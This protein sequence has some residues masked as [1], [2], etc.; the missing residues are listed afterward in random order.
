MVRI[1]IL[2][3]GE[4]DTGDSLVVV[5]QQQQQQQRCCR[6]MYYIR[7]LSDDDVVPIL[8]GYNI[9]CIHIQMYKWEWKRKD[10]IL[11]WKDSLLLLLLLLLLPSPSSSSSKLLLLLL[12]CC[13]SISRNLLKL[14]WKNSIILYCLDFLSIFVFYI[15]YIAS[16][17]LIW[18]WMFWRCVLTVFVAFL[19]IFFYKYDGV[20]N[21]LYIYIR[22]KE[23]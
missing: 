4:E 9:L 12:C 21:N 3:K 8:P 23:T 18:Y 15:K 17:C 1:Y 6:F 5:A 19:F 10:I 16:V 11:I 2:E 20:C 13:G 22:D 7:S 14:E